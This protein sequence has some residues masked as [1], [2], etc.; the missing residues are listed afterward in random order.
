MRSPNA[1]V[2]LSLLSLITATWGI[3]LYVT[4]QPGLGMAAL[5]GAAVVAVC[6]GLVPWL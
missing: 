5:A 3:V 6:V 2:S 4:G 1:V